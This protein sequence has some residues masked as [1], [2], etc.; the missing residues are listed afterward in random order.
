MKNNLTHN[1]GETAASVEIL[2]YYQFSLLT[3]YRQVSLLNLTSTNCH[4]TFVRSSFIVV[5]AQATTIETT[6][7][8]TITKAQL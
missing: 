5:I 1:L 3:L 4:S 8:T 7:A 6:P 2:D